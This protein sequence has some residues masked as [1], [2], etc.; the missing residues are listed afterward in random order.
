MLTPK[1]YFLHPFVGPK[2]YQKAFC[3]ITKKEQKKQKETQHTVKMPKFKKPW[4]NQKNKKTIFQDS[5]KSKN[6]KVQKTSRKPK[7]HIPEVWRGSTGKSPGIFFSVVFW[8]FRG[9]LDF[10]IF[11]FARV[12]EYCVF[13]LFLFFFGFLEGFWIL[14][15]LLLQESWNLVFFV[16]FVSFWFSRGFLNF[17]IFIFA[18][19]LIFLFFVWFSWGFLD[20]C[21]LVHAVRHLSMCCNHRNSSICVELVHCILFILLKQSRVAILSINKANQ[22]MQTIELSLQTHPLE[23]ANSRVYFANSLSM[24]CRLLGNLSP[25]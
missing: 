13:L 8:F 7:K 4:E 15:F 6:P 1:I 17:G 5:C 14:A 21:I 24:S 23:F 25:M 9:F 16:V 19:V 11:T 20:F 12:L 3:T 22:K 18:G 10:C 2:F